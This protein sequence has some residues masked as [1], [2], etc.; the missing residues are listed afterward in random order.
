MKALEQAQQE[1]A[2]F[3]SELEQQ[4][5]FSR[6][7]QFDGLKGTARAAGMA[8]ALAGGLTGCAT[9]DLASWGSDNNNSDVQ[10]INYGESIMGDKKVPDGK[11]NEKAKDLLK[12]KAQKSLTKSQKGPSYDI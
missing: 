5:G 6:T 8:A 2:N 7:K 1:G 11:P 12:I 10:K 4:S 3:R 9:H